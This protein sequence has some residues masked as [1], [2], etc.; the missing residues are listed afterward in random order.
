VAA[1]VGNKG[2]KELLLPVMVLPVVIPVIA[3]AGQLTSVVLGE[4]LTSNWL[5]VIVFL[6]GYDLIT[7]L[8]GAAGFAWI[9][10]LY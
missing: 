3:L 5:I 2:G 8:G 4:P 6:I 9:S 7:I 1:Y 10:E